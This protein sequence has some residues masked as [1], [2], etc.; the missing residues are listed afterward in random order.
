VRYS[1]P[2][3]W[4]RG[5]FCHDWTHEAFGAIVSCVGGGC[6]HANRIDITGANFALEQFGRRDGKDAG[7][8]AEIEDGAGPPLARDTIQHVEAAARRTMVAGAKSQRG[9]DLDCDV[10]GL[11]RVASMRA[12]ND[13][14]SRPYRLQPFERSGNPIPFIDA[15]EPCR[16]SGGAR[17]SGDKGTN[18]CF[19]RRGAKIGLDD[20][21]TLVPIAWV[22]RLLEGRG[23]GRGRIE[24]LDNDGGDPARRRL[25]TGKTHDMGSAI[26]G[27]AFEH[28]GSYHGVSRTAMGR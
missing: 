4:M 9:L 24:C 13:E 22:R 25:V 3:H 12:M 20:P 2:Q 11:T 18:I 8:G 14:A 26:L 16:A 10:I 1:C 19:V 21:G 6:L 17:N 15:A 23:G 27:E 7:A 28:G 5:T